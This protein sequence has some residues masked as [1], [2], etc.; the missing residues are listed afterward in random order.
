MH[1]AESPEEIELLRSQSGEFVE[2]FSRIGFWRPEAF[3]RGGRPLDY[4]RVL[5]ECGRSLVVHGNYLDDEE[6]R[7][8][9]DHRERMAVVFCA[10]THAYFGHAP[11]PLPKLMAL[12]ATVA[13]GT[14]SRASNPDLDML[15]EL[16]AARRAFPQLPPAKLLELGTLAGARALGVEHL[17]G[18]LAPGK[19]ANMAVVKVLT[20]RSADP[21]ELALCDEARVERTTLARYRDGRYWTTSWHRA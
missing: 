20:D 21:Q 11:H 16:R 18:S 14:D 1:L 13:I 9:A 3:A 10:R 12:G 7:F 17:L 15:A 5:A 8:V 19:L 2:L 4:L 6:L